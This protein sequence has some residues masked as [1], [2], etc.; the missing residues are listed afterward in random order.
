MR[1]RDRQIEIDTERE[2]EIG[3]R[4]GRQYCGGRLQVVFFL[5]GKKR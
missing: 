4:G 5:G 3:R 1:D 2:K